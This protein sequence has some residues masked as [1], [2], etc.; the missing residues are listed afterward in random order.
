MKEI[1]ISPTAQAVAGI[2]VLGAIGAAIA[3]QAPEIRR[4]MAIRSM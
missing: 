2:V 1:S 4:Y 3:A